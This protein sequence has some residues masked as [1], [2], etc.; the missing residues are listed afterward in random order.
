MLVLS[1]APA[2]CCDKHETATTAA[3][4]SPPGCMYVCMYVCIYTH[5][6]MDR[7]PPPFQQSVASVV[8]AHNWLTGELCVA[9]SPIPWQRNSNLCVSPRSS[10]E[11]R[12]PLH[13]ISVCT[14]PGQHVA[15]RVGLY[16]PQVQGAEFGLG[17]RWRLALTSIGV[18][19]P[20]LGNPHRWW[21][22]A[23]GLVTCQGG[24]PLPDSSV[25]HRCFP[26]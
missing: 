15:D 25:A 21:F 20:S 26:G 11:S 13:V 4:L 19:G 23:S 17:V 7:H 1:Y 16:Q 2:A 6:K 14:R 9:V 8:S 22:L 18:P 24:V 3:C 10:S 12:R 5:K